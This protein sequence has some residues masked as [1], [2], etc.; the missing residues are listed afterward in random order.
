MTDILLTNF[1][2]LTKDKIYIEIMEIKN[3]R[4]EL[5]TMCTSVLKE[6]LPVCIDTGV[7]NCQPIT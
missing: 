3:K 2:P 5:N 7:S 6:L 4:C 1:S